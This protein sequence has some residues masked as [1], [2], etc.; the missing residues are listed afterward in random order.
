MLECEEHCLRDCP[1]AVLQR[2][3]KHLTLTHNLPL[4]T[5]GL[6][7][8]TRLY[9]CLKM[10]TSPTHPQWGIRTVV[11]PPDDSCKCLPLLWQ[12]QPCLRSGGCMERS[13]KGL[14]QWANTQQLASHS[15]HFVVSCLIILASDEIG[16]KSLRQTTTSNVEQSVT[17]SPNQLVIV[18]LKCQKKHQRLNLQ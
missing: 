11:Q 7:S 17:I 5:S 15:W 14:G 8:V 18:Q 4:L 9:L 16:S 6:L 1:Q 12:H 3:G 10:A 13:W 2:E